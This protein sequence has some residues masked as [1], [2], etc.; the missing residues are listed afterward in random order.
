[1][2]Y[3]STIDQAHNK[4]DKLAIGD[5]TINRVWKK[6]VSDIARKIHGLDLL[7]PAE[8]IAAEAIEFALKDKRVTW[9]D[10]PASE[11]RLVCTA[12]KVAGW[13]ICKEIK[14][15]KRAIVSYEL[16]FL[17]E[18]IDGETREISKAE[19][20]YHMINYRAE[21]CHKDMIDLGRLARSRLDAF[22]AREGVSSRDIDIFKDR[23]LNTMQTDVVC[24]KHFIEPCNLYKI[25]CEVKKILAAKGR[26]LVRE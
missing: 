7:K 11:K 2:S 6:I 8:D 21:E 23:V 5:D 20:N 14:K 22:L 10:T 12:R 17:E 3:T 24:R 15:A 25:V 19:A 26:E 4:N 18:R 13:S 9:D 16:D 1:M